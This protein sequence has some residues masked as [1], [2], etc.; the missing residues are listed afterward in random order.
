M[1]DMLTD[2]ILTAVPYVEIDTTSFAKALLLSRCLFDM[3]ANS[4]VQ[5]DLHLKTY[6]TFFGGTLE[7]PSVIFPAERTLIVGIK[8]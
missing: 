7:S 5:Q 2:V 1:P 4:S 3:H 6:F 8:Y